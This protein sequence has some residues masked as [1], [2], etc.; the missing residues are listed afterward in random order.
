M[1]AKNILV[2]DGKALAKSDNVL[3]NKAKFN[4][5]KK[6]EAFYKNES[7]ALCLNLKNLIEHFGIAQVEECLQDLAYE[8]YDHE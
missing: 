2:F 3:D 6:V 7:R 8:I 4:H 5:A 1:S